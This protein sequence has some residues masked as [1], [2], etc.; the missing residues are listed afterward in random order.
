VRPW[1]GSG[2]ALRFAFLRTMPTWPPE[3]PAAE[4]S[5]GCLCL[6]TLQDRC[7]EG[8]GNCQHV[9]L[10][11]PGALGGFLLLPLWGS[12]ILPDPEVASTHR[13]MRDGPCR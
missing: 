5:D 7:E 13:L 6:L 3:L 11:R 8:S 2:Q 4:V 12:S 10:S 9:G 1:L